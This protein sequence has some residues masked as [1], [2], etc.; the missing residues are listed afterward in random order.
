MCRTQISVTIVGLQMGKLV[1]YFNL[2]G[3]FW[4]FRFSDNC[5]R[6]KMKPGTLCA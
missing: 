6:K 1:D 3:G 4:I 5:F 2:I